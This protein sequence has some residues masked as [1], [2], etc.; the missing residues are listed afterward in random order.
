MKR[1]KENQGVQGP[2]RQEGVSSWVLEELRRV[3]RVETDDFW[4]E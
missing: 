4:V 3:E 2:P 1:P